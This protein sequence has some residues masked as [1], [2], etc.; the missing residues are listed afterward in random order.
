MKIKKTVNNCSPINV[1][2]YSEIYSNRK[3]YLRELNRGKSFDFSEWRPVTE[4]TN[5]D[6]KQDFV[7]YK[8][9]L[10]ACKKTHI[11]EKEPVLKYIDNVPVGVEGDDWIFVFS[12]I[13]S[14]DINVTTNG[15]EVIAYAV[16]NKEVQD[17]YETEYEKL[18]DPDVTFKPTYE[19]TQSQKD[20]NREIYNLLH[21]DLT[22]LIYIDGYLVKLYSDN[23]SEI[24]LQCVW[25]ESIS[26]L[27][28]PDGMC[29]WNIML[30]DVGWTLGHLGYK[31]IPYPKHSQSD[32]TYTYPMLKTLKDNNQLIAGQIYS[33]WIISSRLCSKLRTTSLGFINLKAINSHTFDQDAIYRLVFSEQEFKVKYSIDNHEG[34]E[35]LNEKGGIVFKDDYYY[36]DDF[37]NIIWSDSEKVIECTSASNNKVYIKWNNS[38]DLDTDLNVY[39]NSSCTEK[40]GMGQIFYPA[41]GVIYEMEDVYGNK[42]PYDFTLAQTLLWTSEEDEYTKLDFNK[43]DECPY[44]IWA[45]VF[46]IKGARYDTF[47]NCKIQTPNTR[48][49][50]S[51]QSQ[52]ALWKGLEVNIGVGSNV[53]S[54]GMLQSVN[55][56][57]WCSIKLPNAMG[58]NMTFESGCV[59]F[60]AS[61]EDIAYNS[62]H[63]LSGNY[64][65]K[66]INLTEHS[67]K[68]YLGVNSNEEIKIWNPVDLILHYD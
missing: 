67:T 62:T 60:D 22:I 31:K 64:N 11:S 46:G 24:E 43:T 1:N 55:I 35:V 57:D 34:F 9:T 53:I 12:G 32:I 51:P 29:Y 59:D 37:W 36:I 47:R 4:Y 6:F 14:G 10:L 5:N 68:F 25:D 2:N 19:L 63:V 54:K 21:E 42:A 65:G 44:P 15:I 49:D 16:F 18:V 30:I 40:L 28:Y 52:I 3:G 41:E 56:G 7:S 17:W 50:N 27:M 48:W 58:S 8:N 33:L 66:T 61:C 20:H 39:K 45:Y 26:F 13:G 38:D 23:G